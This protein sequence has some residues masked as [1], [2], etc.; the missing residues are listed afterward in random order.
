MDL[1]LQKLTS[2]QYCLQ[3]KKKKKEKKLQTEL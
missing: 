1:I 2:L 3:K